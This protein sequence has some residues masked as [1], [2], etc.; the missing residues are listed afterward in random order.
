MPG[1]GDSFV[2]RYLTCF[3]QQLIFRLLPA[4]Y[5]CRLSL[6]KVY[7]ESSLLLLLL[8]QVEGHACQLLSFAY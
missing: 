5:Y 7:V 2:N 6:L 4:T 3:M 8:S 1:S